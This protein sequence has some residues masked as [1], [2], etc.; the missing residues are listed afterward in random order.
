MDGQPPL[1]VKPGDG[2]GTKH[3]AHN[4]GTETWRLVGVYVVE[5]G[6]PLATPAP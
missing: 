4:T 2:G 3:D 5:K 6:K 1:K